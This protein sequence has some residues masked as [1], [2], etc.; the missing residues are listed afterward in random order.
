MT[1]L[2]EA[3]DRVCGKRLK[4]MIPTLLLALEQHGRLQLGQADRDRVLVISVNK[5]RSGT[6][7]Y[8]RPNH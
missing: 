2:W 5:H 1:A 7:G 3:S 6:P 4:V 8:V